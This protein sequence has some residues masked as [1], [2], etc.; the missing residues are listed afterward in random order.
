MRL[1]EGPLLAG[2][3]TA[4]FAGDL[5]HGGMS[6][7]C[8][9]CTYVDDYSDEELGWDIPLHCSDC[10]YEILYPKGGEW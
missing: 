1:E 7:E 4:F 5:P 10:G 6:L 3:T 2:Q 8:Q 9:N